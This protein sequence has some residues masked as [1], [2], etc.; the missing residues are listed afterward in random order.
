LAEAAEETAKKPAAEKTKDEPMRTRAM[1][2]W[3]KE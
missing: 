1:R 3:W 2:R